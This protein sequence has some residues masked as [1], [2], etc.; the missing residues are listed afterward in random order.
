MVTLFKKLF[1]GGTENTE[2]AT[3]TNTSN[4]ELQ[5]LEHFVDYVVKSLVDMPNDIHVTSHDGEKENTKVIRIESNQDDIGKIIG[6]KRAND[7]G[8]S[9]FNKWCSWSFT[10]KNFSRGCRLIEN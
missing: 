9:Y 2:P 1:G 4:D 3:D 8:Y 7:Y 10:T 6:K 5:D